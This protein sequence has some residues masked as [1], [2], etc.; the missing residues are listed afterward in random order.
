MFHSDHSRGFTLIELLIVMLI[1]SISLSIVLPLTVAQVDKA[2]QRSE[3]QLAVLFYHKAVQRAFFGGQSV[4]L[5]FLGKELSYGQAEERR[6]LKF[7]YLS[8]R[9]AEVMLSSTG[10]IPAQKVEATIEGRIWGLEL[11]K[12]EANWFNPD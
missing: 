1:M 10:V 12:D 7:E 3:R 6:Q 2:R 8:F 9:E 11:D 5:K 4:R